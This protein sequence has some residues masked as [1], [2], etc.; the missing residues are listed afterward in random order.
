M[1]PLTDCK[2][3]EIRIRIFDWSHCPVTGLPSPAPGS[4]DVN[5]QEGNTNLG[6]V[7][8]R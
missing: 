3:G 6:K 4:E 7:M 2:E 5:E 1:A 8:L